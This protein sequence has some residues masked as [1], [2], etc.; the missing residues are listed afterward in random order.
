M[1]L[2]QQLD[3]VV[4][5]L[6][7]EYQRSRSNVTTHSFRH[8]SQFIISRAYASLFLQTK[9]KKDLRENNP[10]FPSFQASS[11]LVF[12]GVKIQRFRPSP[13]VNHLGSVEPCKRTA[14]L[15]VQGQTAPL[16]QASIPQHHGGPEVGIKALKPP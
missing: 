5:R 13:P 3:F 12:G 7:I 16:K 8:E 14:L 9:F 1:A 11:N 10:I 15:R 2:F 4:F 6:G